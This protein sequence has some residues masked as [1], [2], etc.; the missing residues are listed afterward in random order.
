M[1]DKTPPLLYLVRAHEPLQQRKRRCALLVAARDGV[2]SSLC[3]SLL[4]RQAA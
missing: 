2:P 4:P 1:C 3:L